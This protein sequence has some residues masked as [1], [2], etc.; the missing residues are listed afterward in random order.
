MT[1]GWKKLHNT[2]L[3]GLYPLLSVIRIIMVGGACSA[4]GGE[5]GV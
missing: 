2:E 1:G 3:R 4:N 5:E